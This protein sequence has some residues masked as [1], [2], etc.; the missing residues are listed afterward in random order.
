MAGWKSLEC[1]NYAV[2]KF[3]FR[4]ILGFIIEG[5][6][7]LIKKFKNGLLWLKLSNTN[8]FRKKNYMECNRFMWGQY[9]RISMFFSHFDLQLG[10]PLIITLPRSGTLS[11]RASFILLKLTRCIPQLT[12]KIYYLARHTV[13][14]SSVWLTFVRCLPFGRQTINGNFRQYWNK[15]PKFYTWQ[16]W[17]MP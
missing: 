3:R 6:T 14:M 1:V 15:A 16:C 2:L 7:K 17:K 9:K 11:P 10:N 8:Q 5:V 13:F 12:C 4:W